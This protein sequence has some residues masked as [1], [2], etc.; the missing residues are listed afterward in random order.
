LAQSRM[1]SRLVSGSSPWYICG[2]RLAT[3]LPNPPVDPSP[4]PVTVLAARD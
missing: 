1:Q 2:A 4:G 3:M